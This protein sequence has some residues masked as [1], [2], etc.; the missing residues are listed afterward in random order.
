ML[1]SKY[2][3]SCNRQKNDNLTSDNIYTDRGVSVNYLSLYNYYSKLNDQMGRIS[4]IP[5]G[6]TLTGP[7]PEP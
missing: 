5:V 7:R 2:S 1:H 3:G 4:W 6:Y